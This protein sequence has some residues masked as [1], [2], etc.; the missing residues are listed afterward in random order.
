MFS[1]MTAEMT[2]S[3]DV[4]KIIPAEQFSQE[5]TLSYLIPGERPYFLLR[6]KKEEFV[7]TNFA[8]IISRGESATNTRRLTSRYNY[9]ETILT[10]VMFETAGISVT[11]RDCELKFNIGGQAHNIDIWKNETEQAKGVYRCL[12]ELS[13]N[14]V[15]NQVLMEM[16]T[17][18]LASTKNDNPINDKGFISMQWAEAAMARYRPE[19]YDYVFQ[20][21]FAPK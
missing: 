17:S 4:C 5:V 18:A 15:R 21:F 1:K 6:S 19:S 11:D 16:A 3:A 8:F 13:R 2:G 7:F 14:M 20:Q 10:N 12:V 9:F